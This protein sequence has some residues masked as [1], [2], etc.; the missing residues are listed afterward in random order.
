MLCV[1]SPLE[2][3]SEKQRRVELESVRNFVAKT[4]L[5][6]SANQFS[7]KSC[8]W[9]SIA[10]DITSPSYTDTGPPFLYGDSDTPPNL[11]AFY[12]TLGIRMTYSRLKPPGALWLHKGVGSLG[13]Y[14]LPHDF[15]RYSYSAI[16]A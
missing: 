14:G 1:I 16:A 4:V 15:G 3:F 13:P 10:W 9:H 11:V 6:E 7:L 2:E 12:D 8:V 5:V